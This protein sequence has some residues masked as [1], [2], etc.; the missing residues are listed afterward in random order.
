MSVLRPKFR[1]ADPLPADAATVD[2]WHAAAC[3]IA[4]DAARLAD[5]GQGDIA[6]DLDDVASALRVI[7]RRYAQGPKGASRHD[8]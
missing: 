6:A 4:A 3:D 8:H 2:R 7:A 5:T 1:P